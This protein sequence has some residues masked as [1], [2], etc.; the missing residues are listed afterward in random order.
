M[1]P[2]SRGRIQTPGLAFALL[3]EARQPCSIHTPDHVWWLLRSCNVHIMLRP[4]IS[5]AP[6]R[7]ELLQPS[8][9]A[10]DR[11]KGRSVM[12]TGTFVSF[13]TG[14]SPAALLALWAAHQTNPSLS[15]TVH[16]NGADFP[17]FFCV[18]N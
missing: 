5:L 15:A 10:P 3:V 13:L 1:V 2:G 16:L 4:A 12:T 8:L 9:P 14:L 11:S 17:A 18:L 6:L 7:T